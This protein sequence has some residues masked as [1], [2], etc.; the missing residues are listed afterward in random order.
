MTDLPASLTDSPEASPL[1]GPF[2]VGQYAAQLKRRLQ[3]FAR[4]QLVGEVW[5]FRGSRARVYFELRDARGAVPCS[6]WRTD[7]EALGLELVDG[8][9]VVAGGGCDYYPGSSASSPSF[10]FSVT[11]L[12]IE[13]EGDLL[14]G[15]QRL[16]RQFDAEGLCEPQ[17]R[18]ARPLVPR[19]IGVVTGEQG[20]ARD[21]VLAGLRRRGWA[22]RL[23][24]AFVPVQDRHAAPR[25]AAALRELAALEEVEVVIV[26]R[27]GGSLADLLAFCDETLC[28]T[29][30]LLR[31]PVIASVGHHT[32]RTLIDDVAAVSCST[33]THAAEAAVRID[34]RAARADLAASARQLER[35][36]RV[37]VVGRARHLAQLSR[38]PAEHVA[39]HRVHLHQRLRE[40]RASAR[41][42]VADSG[43]RASR[44][45]LVLDRK[46]AVARV[47][48]DRRH[49]ELQGRARRFAG[50]QKEAVV[51]RAE[52][53]ERLALALGAHDPER[54]LAR[55]Y[56]LI[57][58]PAG[59]PVTTAQGAQTVRELGLRFHDGRVRAR[60]HEPGE[61]PSS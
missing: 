21:D 35:H 7:F 8:M 9:R 54:T 20:K 17:K 10:T 28:R 25:I 43:R 29:V 32:D 16:R 57:E 36:G 41:R 30:A 14:A 55:G 56:A 49:A 22:G 11:E 38:A 31:T 24:W 18:L 13:G 42:R 47:D 12:R 59:S 40:L 37:A 51:R 27:G 44:H 19:T 50:T 52:D 26:A 23:V 4:V 5:G 61:E 48:R 2:P 46:A 60:V 39:R 33:P 6:M 1:P 3:E 34:C 58:D 53:L 45:L 15:L